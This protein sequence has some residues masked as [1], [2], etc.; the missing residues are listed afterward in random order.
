MAGLAAQVKDLCKQMEDIAADAEK[1]KQQ[2]A[3]AAAAPGN[4]DD[5]GSTAFDEF[6]LPMDLDDSNWEAIK[7][8]TVAHVPEVLAE[9]SVETA[10]TKLTA[11]RAEL[12]K[13][14]RQKEQEMRAVNSKIGTKGKAAKVTAT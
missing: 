8:Y 3:A 1:K 9:D 2:T 7:D 5:A 6:A 12:A 4:E 14:A 10:R 13:R 11:H